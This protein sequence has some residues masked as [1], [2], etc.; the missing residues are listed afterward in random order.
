MP[1]L[2]LKLTTKLSASS[3][4]P[5]CFFASSL[6]V[7]SNSK[8]IKDTNNNQRQFN[9]GTKI[10]PIMT[11]KIHNN[12]ALCINWFKND[13]K[14]LTSSSDSTAKIIDLSSDH[15]CLNEIQLC[16]HKKRAKNVCSNLFDDNIIAISGSE[17]IIFL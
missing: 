9:I 15:L 4:F 1:V 10:K 12:A 8:V 17:G 13:T 11:K 5:N 3:I 6:K 2:S 7:K 14:L 16:G